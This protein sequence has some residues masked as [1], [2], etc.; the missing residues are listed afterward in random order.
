MG[1]TEHLK[2]RGHTWYVRVQIP[3]PLWVAAEGRRE[4]V[5]S[6]KTRDVQE[7]NRRKHI[8]I[9]EFKRRISALEG[10][11][12]DPLADVIS[13]A[14]EFRAAHEQYKGQVLYTEPNGQPYTLYDE[15]LTQV[16]DQARELAESQGHGLAERYW[17]LATGEGTLVRQLLDPWFAERVEVVRG[18][19]LSQDRAVMR[20]FLEWAEED[21]S[22]SQVTRRK[23]GDFIGKLLEPASGIK[24]K[25]VNRY[26]S[27]L[28]AF[29]KWLIARGHAEANP[30]LGFDLGKRSG[31][32]EASPRAQWNDAALLKLLTGHFTPKFQQIL[33]DLIR[34]AVMTGARLDELC[35]L[36][37][38]DIA[39]RPD[40]WWLTIRE[41][42]TAAAVREVP[43]HEAAAHVL[44]RR[45]K[46]PDG[47]VFSGL[48]AGGPDN[49]RGWY[50]SK[51][52]T[53][54]RRQ[55]GLD[56]PG[57][58]FHSLRNTFME[59]M[60]GAGVPESTVKLIVGHKRASLTFGHYSKG[61][62]VDLRMAV[63]KARYSKEV[64]R[65]IR[66]ESAQRLNAIC[67]RGEAKGGSACN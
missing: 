1:T 64:M 67:V 39:K 18:Q 10:A 65:L 42:K 25:T 37:T 62:R 59:S 51:A 3:Q 9:A 66:S 63:G 56:G 32:A 40:G 34:L 24:R 45:Q 8:H 28:S 61:M 27:T 31:R 12:A 2:R 57:Q 21:L 55:L 44:E 38:E 13:K 54:Y 23:A 36:R 47:F 16:S 53:R 4:F 60:E 48:T 20:A 41:G 15:L 52:F 58:V 35:A 33:H 50:V 5:K 6:L 17:T 11:R 43:V 26:R 49:K 29:W 46:N 7:A 19:T 22:V 30:W 14:L